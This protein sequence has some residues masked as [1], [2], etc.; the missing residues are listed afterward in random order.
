[1]QVRRRFARAGFTKTVGL[2]AARSVEAALL[3]LESR[4]VNYLAKRGSHT[5]AAQ[6]RKAP[7]AEV[8]LRAE[9][10]AAISWLVKSVLS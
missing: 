10:T 7:D 1:M 5:R 6:R 8:H 4:Q 2:A 9:W 3:Q